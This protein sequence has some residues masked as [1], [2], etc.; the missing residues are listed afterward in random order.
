MTSHVNKLFFSYSMFVVSLLSPLVG[1]DWSV[2]SGL[3]S[4][5]V[6]SGVNVQL[7][8]SQSVS[9]SLITHCASYSTTLLLSDQLFTTQEFPLECL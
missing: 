9:S 6:S 2:F 4:L 7:V 5:S 3:P 1:G 8:A